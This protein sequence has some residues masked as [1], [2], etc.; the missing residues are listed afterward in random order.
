[1]IEGVFLLCIRICILFIILD[2]KMEFS[3]GIVIFKGVMVS[4]E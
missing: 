1:M 2:N 4:E 3:L